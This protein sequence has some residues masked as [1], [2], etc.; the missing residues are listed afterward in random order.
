MA[1]A[2]GD[3]TLDVPFAGRSEFLTVFV[4]MLRA[5]RKCPRAR[6]FLRV[7]PPLAHCPINRRAG[8]ITNTEQG[9]RVIYVL[10]FYE[11]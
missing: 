3:P 10:R 6:F 2:L 8:F 11:E 5:R 9:I 1:T 7:Q 4:T